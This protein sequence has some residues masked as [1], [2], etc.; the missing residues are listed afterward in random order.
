MSTETCE[1]CGRE[2]PLYADWCVCVSHEDNDIPDPVKEAYQMS[3]E[4]KEWSREIGTVPLHET[5]GKPMFL[6]NHL[7]DG[8]VNGVK[9]TV[10]AIISGGSIIVSFENGAE[11]VVR[12]RDV[13]EAAVEQMKKRDQ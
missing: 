13:V 3:K 12:M 7:A 10:G 2:V 8:E 4:E 1:E 6:K 5:V 9:F 11:Y